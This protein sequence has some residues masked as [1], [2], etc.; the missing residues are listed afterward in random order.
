MSTSIS[1]GFDNPDMTQA[2]LD[3]REDRKEQER[4]ERTKAAKDRDAILDAIASETVHV[5]LKAHRI[6]MHVL[7][8]EEEDWTE[9]I[10]DEF[11]AFEDEDELPPEKMSDYIEARDRMVDMLV[12]KSVED[13]Y[14]RAFWKQIPKRLRQEVLSDLMEG[15]EEAARAGN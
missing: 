15:G 12:D 7:S 2:I 5:R 1:E 9:D 4:E 8:G 13:V 14:D 10:A 3:E 11:A 6:E